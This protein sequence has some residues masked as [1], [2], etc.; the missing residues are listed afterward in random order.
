MTSIG[1]QSD[2]SAMSAQRY[3]MK[4]VAKALQTMQYPGRSEGD[5][6]HSMVLIII[7]DVEKHAKHKE[8]GRLCHTKA[9]VPRMTV[10]A[11]DKTTARCIFEYA[12]NHLQSQKEPRPGYEFVGVKDNLSLAEMLSKNATWFTQLANR[13]I[14]MWTI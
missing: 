14:I 2:A 5:A 12:N 3:A 9:A 1:A 6:M 10:L 11:H 13:A 7:D 4:Y 8:G